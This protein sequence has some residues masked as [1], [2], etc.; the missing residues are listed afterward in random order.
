MTFTDYQQATRKTAIYQD[1]IERIVERLA[2]PT[3]E[4]QQELRQILH[5]CYS[6]LGLANEAG[7]VAGVLKKALRD[8]GA[9]TDG[10]RS[11]LNKELGDTGWYQAETATNAKLSLEYVVE[12]N[13]NKLSDRAERGVLQG[14]GDNR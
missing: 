10:V 6:V 9:I 8:D 5:L 11:K 14:S 12:T 1:S 13:L 4:A 3:P 7:E 2:K